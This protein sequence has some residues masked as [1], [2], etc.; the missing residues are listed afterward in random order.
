MGDRTWARI[1]VQKPYYYLLLGTK[2]GLEAI[3]ISDEIDEFGTIVEF[4]DNEANY[5][6]MPYLQNVLEDIKA[7]YNHEW[8]AGGDYGAGIEYVRLTEEGELSSVQ[9]YESV[10]NLI[11][12]KYLLDD[13]N[14]EKITTLEEVKQKLTELLESQVPYGGVYVIED[15]PLREFSDEEKA[16]IMKNTME[17]A[18]GRFGKV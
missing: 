15:V 8:H 3:E 17:E 7:P 2:E 13:I 6:D 1:T 5:G 16:I 12:A 4:V 11:S 9:V 10:E 18:N 14:E